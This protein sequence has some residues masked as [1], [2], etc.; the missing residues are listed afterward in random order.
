VSALQQARDE[1]QARIEA[2]TASREELMAATEGANSD[3]EHDP[4]GAT[5]AFEREQLTAL[6]A[7]ARRSLAAAEEALLREQDG[8]YGACGSCGQPIGAE[9]L[10]A[11]PTATTC[12]SCAR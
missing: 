12:I 6:L 1:A 11:R 9:R 7:Q 4:E 8:T 3:D 2:L 10:E 5:L